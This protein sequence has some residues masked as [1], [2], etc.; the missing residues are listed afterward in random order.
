MA[1]APVGRNRSAV[2]G[3][4]RRPVAPNRAA[5]RS[6]LGLVWLGPAGSSNAC[7]HHDPARGQKTCAPRMGRGGC[8]VAARGVPMVH[9]RDKG[10]VFNNPRPIHADGVHP[11]PPTLR[12]PH[13]HSGTGTMRATIAP[14]G[15]VRSKATGHVLNAI[16]WNAFRTGSP[17][18]LVFPLP[19]MPHA[20]PRFPGRSGRQQ[21]QNRSA[22]A[23]WSDRSGTP[24]SRRSGSRSPGAIDLV[25]SAAA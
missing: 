18:H 22:F 1:L 7:G 8:R 23:A 2:D 17:D 19:D 15:G 9:Y 14:S 11:Y 10:L 25:S 3:H 24:G 21:F 20:Q 16:G 6:G 5:V 13:P 4:G 12:P